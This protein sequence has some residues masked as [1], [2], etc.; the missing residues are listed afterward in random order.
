MRRAALLERLPEDF[1]GPILAALSS[2]KD[3]RSARLACKAFRRIFDAVC[4]RH[5]DVTAEDL[6]QLRG[7]LPMALPQLKTLRFLVADYA[8]GEREELEARLLDMLARGKA[9]WRNLQRVEVAGLQP[10]GRAG[11]AD[12][13]C[14]LLAGLLA[15]PQLSA[16]VLQSSPLPVK[17]SLLLPMLPQ[18]TRLDLRRSIEAEPATHICAALRQLTNLQVRRKR[19]RRSRGRR[20]ACAAQPRGGRAGG[21][22]PAPAARLSAARRQQAASRRL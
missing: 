1:L 13:T 16:L 21:G 14:K 8:G 12:S 5:L 7:A 20:C 2:A 22:A 9:L 10:P 6:L 18:L 17:A 15:F 3:K 4:P 11:G 19:R